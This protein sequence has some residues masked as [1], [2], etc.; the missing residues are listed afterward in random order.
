MVAIQIDSFII[1]CSGQQHSNT[2]PIRHRHHS[3]KVSQSNFS[4]RNIPDDFVFGD[5]FSVCRFMN[6]VP[7]KASSN[8][9]LALKGM[10]YGVSVCVCVMANIVDMH[11]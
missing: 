5:G 3:R 10:D 4:T 2:K 11:E 6:G 7:T 9:K 1:A 8:F